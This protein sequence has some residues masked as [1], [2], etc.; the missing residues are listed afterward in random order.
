MLYLH[1]HIDRSDEE[2]ALLIKGNRAVI[3]RVNAQEKLTAAESSG[4]GTDI[5]YYHFADPRPLSASSTQIDSRR[6]TFFSTVPGP[7]F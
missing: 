1:V 5:S 3:F 7:P 4:K 2:S 6:I